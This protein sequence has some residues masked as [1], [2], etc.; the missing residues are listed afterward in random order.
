MRKEY[1]AIEGMI[2][3]YEGAVGFGSGWKSRLWMMGSVAYVLFCVYYFSEISEM[4]LEY[5]GQEIIIATVGGENTLL[6]VIANMV[7]A[8]LA[9]QGATSLVNWKLNEITWKKHIGIEKFFPKSRLHQELFDIYHEEYVKGLEGDALIFKTLQRGK[10][11][12]EEIVKEWVKTREER[13]NSKLAEEE[14]RIKYNQEVL[15]EMEQ[16]DSRV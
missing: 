12:L 10:S 11:R 13:E 3:S 14:G 1:R 8:Y 15:K 5:F 9:V 4:V 16:P 2:T 6:F 7:I